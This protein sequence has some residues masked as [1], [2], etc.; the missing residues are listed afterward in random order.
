M[1]SRLGL[2]VAAV[3]CLI[4]TALGA[5]TT[6]TAAILEFDWGGPNG[7]GYFQV[8]T[9]TDNIIVT[10]ISTGNL[11]GGGDDTHYYGPPTGTSEL[12]CATSCQAIF[13]TQGSGA[14]YGLVTLTLSFPDIL[15]ASLWNGKQ[16]LD[17][18][19]INSSG[20]SAHDGI[21][22]TGVFQGTGTIE[23]YVI[24]ADPI[25]TSVPEPSTWAMMI[26][27]FCGLGFVACRRKRKAALQTAWLRE[28]LKFCRAIEGN[29]RGIIRRA[30]SAVATATVGLLVLVSPAHSDV[31]DQGFLYSD[32]S[33]TTL[34]FPGAFDTELTGIS[35]WDQIVGHYSNYGGPGGALL[36]YGGSF[37]AIN[38]PGASSTSFNGISSNYTQIVGNYGQFN[39]GF[40]Y[41]GNSFTNFNYPGAYT[42]N[43]YGINAWGQVVG[44]YQLVGPVSNPVISGFIYR[45]GSF[46]DFNFPGAA[47]TKPLGINDSGE[48][49][50]IYY[51]NGQFNGFLYNGDYFITLNR[52]GAWYTA[53]FGI[54]NRGQIVGTYYTGNADKF[55]PNAFV[56]SDGNYAT[57]DVPGALY[58]QAFG[59][60]DFG[61]IVGRYDLPSSVPEP[62][63]WAMMILGFLGLGFMAYRKKSNLR[64]T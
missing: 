54:N 19:E 55:F 2:T 50:G 56:Y 51:E 11:L 25:M 48:I 33:Y 46:Y 17:I 30:I 23:R 34:N 41:N 4:G 7:G 59:I 49:V 18:F 47:Y 36:Y 15:D 24:V 45:G 27:G 22:A 10:S 16:P 40:Q 13:T 38:V 60:N 31:G 39:S 52:S 53:P 35:N 20:V 28:I 32:G 44:T 6:A 64:L 12:N 57:L 62:S 58:T 61:Q 5:S 63:T 37:T 14:S 3:L 42:T 43:P 8:D 9:S 1:K 29:V 26:L 21:A